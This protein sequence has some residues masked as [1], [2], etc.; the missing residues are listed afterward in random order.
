[1]E[2]RKNGTNEHSCRANIENRLVYTEW[3]GEGETN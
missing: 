3:E 2:S 1:M